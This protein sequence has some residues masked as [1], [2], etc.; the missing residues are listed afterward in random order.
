MKTLQLVDK[1][2][3]PVGQI[4]WLP[5]DRVEVKADDAELASEL[6]ALVERGRTSGLP[7]RGGAQVEREGRKVFVEEQVKVKPDDERFLAALADA[8]NRSTVAGR[9]IFALPR[10]R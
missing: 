9:R 5:P 1:E 8:I 2:R 3:R 7:W 10:E 4:I 6:S